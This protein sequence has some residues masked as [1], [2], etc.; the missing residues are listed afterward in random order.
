METSQSPQKTPHR[1]THLIPSQWTAGSLR[2]PETR[3]TP[4]Y[5]LQ[6]PFFLG[7]GQNTLQNTR[8]Q[9]CNLYGF[10]DN[11]HIYL[12]YYRI[13]AFSSKDKLISES[14]EDGGKT[15]FYQPK[16]FILASISFIKIPTVY[17]EFYRRY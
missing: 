5:V 8:L 6:K 3:R 15:T 10:L 16:F 4:S 7:G 13:Y 2:I 9:H 17:I 14:F 11:I 1:S 12:L